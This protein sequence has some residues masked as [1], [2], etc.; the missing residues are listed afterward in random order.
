MIE[1]VYKTDG[2]ERVLP[3]EKPDV[4][5]GRSSEAD[6]C[7]DDRTVSRLHARITVG[8]HGLFVVDLD[9]RNKTRVNGV[10]VTRARVGPGDTLALGEVELEV[11]ERAEPNVVIAAAPPAAHHV[12]LVRSAEEVRELLGAT[13]TVPAVRAG[14]EVDQLARSNRILAALIGAAHH[15]IEE[16]A[17]QGLL[18]KVMDVV[19]DNVAAE[20][21]TLGLY[22]G[23]HLIP[24]VVRYRGP[25]REG[26]RIV[27]PRAVTDKVRRDEVSIL[28]TDTQR[29]FSGSCSVVSLGI[30]SALCV[31]LWYKGSVIG[32]VYVDEDRHTDNFTSD[33]LDLLSALA[34]HAAVAIE[35]QRLTD[36][37]R[38]EQA[39]RAKLERYHSPGV[40]ERILRH[41]AAETMEM[42]EHDVT[43]SFTDIVGFTAMAE[44]LEPREVGT[45]LNELFAELTECV[46]RHEGTLDKF[47][48]DCIMAV[49]GAPV[50]VPDHAAR[51]ARA[52]LDMQRAMDRLNSG[53]PDRAPVLLRVG[54]N[55]GRAVS[56]DFGSPRR[57]DYS[58]LGDAVN[59]ASRLESGVSRPG[60][61]VIGEATYAAVKDRFECRDLGPQDVRGRKAR[62]TAYRL[63]GE[64][65]AG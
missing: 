19:F 20:R 5:L 46:F 40:V 60:W 29:E 52:A 18:E 24:R 27:I 39:T 2:R 21:G 44:L 8:A 42:A 16:D 9:S 37:V 36:R 32:I 49:F 63:I 30:R 50:D 54:I 1:L 48:G 35:R 55:S 45:A 56:G 28:S 13:A 64:K 7:I 14:A 51:C 61:I 53:R 22:E 34:S 12:T 38:E 57:R 23:E 4:V 47:I 31:P 65:P 11:R 10:V 26:E 15:L 25:N 6:L 3:L 58:V 33:D 43:V 41:G 62:V 59:L 17:L